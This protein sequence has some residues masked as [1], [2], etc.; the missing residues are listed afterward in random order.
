MKRDSIHEA[1]LLTAADVMGKAMMQRKLC[2]R[3]QMFLF[4]FEKIYRKSQ[5]H[6]LA[7]HFSVSELILACQIVKLVRRAERSFATA[8]SHVWADR[9]YLSSVSVPRYHPRLPFFVLYGKG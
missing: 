3:C 2:S 5:K 1:V 9:A 6:Y 8:D 4:L 7:R